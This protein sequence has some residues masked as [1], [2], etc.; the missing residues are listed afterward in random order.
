M[1][2]V[3][4]T[5]APADEA[6]DARARAGD[7]EA[8]RA[9]YG[10]RLEEVYDFVLRI[11]G[12]RE[13]AAD[14]VRETFA[15]AQHAFAE[16]GSNVAPWLFVTARDCA[17]DA[18]RY[19]R[20]RNG[21]VREALQ[22]TGVDGDRV[23]E[24]NVVFD[25][26]LIELVWDAAAALPRDE[27]SL[28]ALHVRHDLPADAIGHELGLNGAVSARLTRAR[29]AFDD[30]VLCQLV[31]RRGRHNCDELDIVVREHE[32]RRVAQHVQRC[33]RC[34]K[35]SRGYV[36]PTEVLG[37][38]ELVEPSGSLRRELFGSTR[39]RRVFGIL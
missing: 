5:A 27:Y 37:A 30:A 33:T 35:S 39:R 38:L 23:P 24:A 36:S 28:L 25:R 19:R 14:V 6:I 18:L 11:V 8:F 7:R 16:R 21:E 4:A 12:E 1:E 3:A 10:P 17:L 20:D 26:E 34:R 29:E 13:L 32:P 9:L 2:A 15:K 22:L 31:A